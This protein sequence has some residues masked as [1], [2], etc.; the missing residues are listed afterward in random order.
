MPDDERT[1]TVIEGS[2]GQFIDNWNDAVASGYLNP[3]QADT[4]LEWLKFTLARDPHQ[5]EH[6][7]GDFW[8]LNYQQMGWR[9]RFW[10]NIIED[11]YLVELTA[12]DWGFR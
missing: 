5:G 12:V 10:Y 8:V 9:V 1:Y 11:D 2:T 7:D 4:D 6:V 3:G